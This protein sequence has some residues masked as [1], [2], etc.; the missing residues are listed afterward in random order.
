MAAARVLFDV[1]S[2]RADGGHMDSAV[3]GDVVELSTDEFKRL[4]DL[5][6]VEKASAKDVKAAAS[7][8]E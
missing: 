5:G 8:D 3:K 7:E 6:A 2:Y 4:E 1:V